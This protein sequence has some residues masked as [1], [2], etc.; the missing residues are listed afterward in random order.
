MDDQQI[1]NRLR[2]L[3]RRVTA[4]IDN[5]K[6]E[7]TQ[8]IQA[9]EMG[10]VTDSNLSKYRLKDDPDAKITIMGADN[11]IRIA[12]YYKVSTDYLLGFTDDKASLR[13]DGDNLIREICDFTGLSRQAV[14]ALHKGKDNFLFSAG[15]SYLLSSKKA[16]LSSIIE[17]ILTC[18]HNIVAEDDRYSHLPGIGSSSETGKHFFYDVF[19]ELP[20]AREHFHQLVTENRVLKERYAREMAMKC[21]DHEKVF[22]ELYPNLVYREDLSP[23]ECA[24]LNY[25]INQ[26]L[27]QTDHK[28]I[29][30]PDTE[31]K[32]KEMYLNY[33]EPNSEQASLERVV[34]VNDDDFQVIYENQCEAFW[35]DYYSQLKK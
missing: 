5:K 22:R 8:A 27:Y 34:Y 16:L 35:K 33:T 12:D 15:L 14:E 19:E 13:K 1:K 20:Q 9:R 6:K 25:E 11:L 7:K 23:E 24:K 3:S 30:P 17:Y 28:L 26:E 10:Y 2:Q 29:L 18:L 4:C 32:I 31:S 21:V